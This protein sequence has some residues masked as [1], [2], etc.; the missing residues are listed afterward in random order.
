MEFNY[1]ESLETSTHKRH[2]KH[3]VSDPKKRPSAK[4]ETR[5]ASHARKARPSAKSE[6]RG[7]SHARKAR[8]RQMKKKVWELRRVREHD[9]RL[10]KATVSGEDTHEMEDKYELSDD[11]ELLIAHNNEA[12]EEA[13]GFAYDEAQMHAKCTCPGDA[14]KVYCCSCINEYWETHCRAPLRELNEHVK[15]KNDALKE[16]L[17]IVLD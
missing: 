9:L 16:K 5:G 4:S 7:A 6:T 11:L 13:W 3:R 15:K 8:D 10:H 2:G 17:K 1:A 14:I 12:L